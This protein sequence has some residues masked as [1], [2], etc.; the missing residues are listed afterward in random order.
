MSVV[1]CIIEIP[2]RKKKLMNLEIILKDGTTIYPSYDPEHKVGVI[3]FYKD[4]F[5]R[6]LITGWGIV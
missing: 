1:T 6:G 3:A 5:D 4:L 2:K